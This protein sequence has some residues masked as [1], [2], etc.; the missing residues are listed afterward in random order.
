MKYSCTPLSSAQASSVRP[1]SSGPLSTTRGSGYAQTLNAGSGRIGEH[2]LTH[3]MDLL[4]VDE[5]RGWH[6]RSW[7]M[8]AYTRHLTTPERE[9]RLGC[10]GSE[11]R[12]WQRV[13][14]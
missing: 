3:A 2:S 10:G 9:G 11:R 4:P 1:R 5:W 6:G 13:E 8:A 14:A 12:S 7:L